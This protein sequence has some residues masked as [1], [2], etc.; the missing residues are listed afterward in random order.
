[1][2][3]VY[4]FPF[5]DVELKQYSLIADN[6]ESISKIQTLLGLKQDGINVAME[7]IVVGLGFIQKYCHIDFQKS[8][9]GDMMAEGCQGVL[10]AS[11]FKFKDYINVE[12]ND[13][14]Y[15]AA[16]LYL[17]R[18]P[19]LKACVECRMGSM[20]DYFPFHAEVVYL[21]CTK[22]C[23]SMCDEG[24]QINLF[25]RLARRMVPGSYLLLVTILD[26]LSPDDFSA[27]HLHLLSFSRICIGSRAESTL[28]IFKIIGT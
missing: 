23:D 3:S 6:V 11:A 19:K 28:W 22:T 25:F 27:D 15:S 17:N 14:S 1:M 13:S 26:S 4:P 5:E 10:F 9:F 21:D 12:I 18:I 7:S 24:F 16:T 20:Q 8:T 2:S